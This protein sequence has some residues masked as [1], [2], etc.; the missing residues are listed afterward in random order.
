MARDWRSDPKTHARFLAYKERHAYF[1]RGDQREPLL[2]EAFGALDD[3]RLEILRTPE[4]ERTEEVRMRLAEIH[5][6]LLID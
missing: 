6:Q 4:A 3:E 1:G 2:Y 5:K